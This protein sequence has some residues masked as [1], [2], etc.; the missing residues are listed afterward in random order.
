MSQDIR[1]R[2]QQKQRGRRKI[3]VF[4]VVLVHFHKLC[5]CVYLREHLAFLWNEVNECMCGVLS[6]RVQ[7]FYVCLNSRIEILAMRYL[8]ITRIN[9]VTHLYLGH[10]II[11][12]R[13]FVVFIYL[14]TEFVF[15]T[16]NRNLH[17]SEQKQ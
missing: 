2:A 1:R 12:F 16:I 8:Y 9:K 14:L 6:I 7:V 13:F 4:V 3:W 11:Y 17:R 10:V 5:V 15:V